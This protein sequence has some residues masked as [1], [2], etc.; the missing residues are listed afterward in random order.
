MNGFSLI[1]IIVVISILLILA[2]MT[3]AG[4]RVFEKISDLGND[5]E[6]IVSILR[7]AQGKTLASDS[8]SQ[9]GVY[10]DTSSSPNKYIL[11][12]GASYASRDPVSDDPHD[13]LGRVEI[14]SINLE[15]GSPEVVFNRLSGTTDQDGD[16][17]LR[18]QDDTL[19]TKTIYIENSGQI[20][21]TLP[22][23]P[24]DFSRIKDSRHVH[25]N[26]SRAI[27]TA[28]EKI[29]LTFDYGGSSTA[30]EIVIADNIKD[31]QI[32]WEGNVSVGGQT[33]KIKI[34]THFLN[35]PVNGTQFSITRDRRYNT[36]SLVVDINGAS[37][38]PDPGTLITYAANGT[39]ALGTS[40]FVSEMQWQ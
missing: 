17:V 32:Y 30:Q 29:V 16:I 36:K 4:F 15:G 11:F 40:I 3:V 20:G 24:S 7:L 33:E 10:F 14:E 21:L 31:G 25:F 13:I 2:V 35:D 8:A 38:D 23:S 9:W 1:E 6:E 26:Y 18:L 12:K 37:S 34:Q 28:T 19:K 22:S 5:A 27:D 39:T